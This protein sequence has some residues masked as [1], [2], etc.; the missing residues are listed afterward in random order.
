MY[1]QMEA[2]FL[3][4]AKNEVKDKMNCTKAFQQASKAKLVNIPNDMN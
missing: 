2:P 1:F 3:S 4:Y